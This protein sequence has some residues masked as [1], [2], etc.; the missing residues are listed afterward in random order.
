MGGLQST[1]SL[2]APRLPNP[3][4]A[5]FKVGAVDDPLER[6]AERV[7]DQV[8]RMPQPLPNSA[9]APIGAILRRKC[10]ACEA[11]EERA[12]RTKPAPGFRAS[13]GMGDAAVAVATGGSPLPTASRAYFEP[14]FGHDLSSVR[15]H[16]HDRAASAARAINARAFTLGRDIAFAPGE[17]APETLAGR[18]LLAHEL[19]HVAQ[20]RHTEPLVQ[21][22]PLPQYKAADQVTELKVVHRPDESDV[23]VLAVKGDYTTPEAVGRLIWPSRPAIPPGVSIK[24]VFRMEVTVT[25][26]AAAFGQQTVFELSGM[27]LFT[28]RT[29]DPSIAQLFRDQGLLEESEALREARAMFQKRHADLGVLVLDNID[30]ALNRVARS[31]PELLEAYYR[32]Y[33]DWP[34]GT[35]ESTS[36]EAGETDLAWRKGGKVSDINIGVLKLINLPQLPTDDPLSLLGSTLIHEFAHTSHASGDVKGP[37][38]GKAYGIENFFSERM[39]DETREKMT[40]DLGERMGDKKAFDTAYQVMKFLYQIIDGQTSKLPSLADVTPQ[41][42][43]AMAAEFVSKNKDDF[44]AELKAFITTEFGTKEYGSLP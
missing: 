17:Y 6:E 24:R 4:Q 15:I 25:E 40:L 35:I 1:S 30:R 44:S 42:A 13:Q 12:I 7:A 14:R 36:K 22:Q 21:R 33:A 34:L 18:Q 31:N 39:G 26:P 23:W 43:R 29:M 38:E 32:R 28:V 3:I 11:E 27:Y 10:A 37:G 5:K 2:L 8:M 20:Q 19:A 41:R 16:T 9:A